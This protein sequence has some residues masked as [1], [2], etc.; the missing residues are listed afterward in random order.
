M[1][2][3]YTKISCT[4]TYKQWK[5]YQKWGK[6]AIYNII[7]TWNTFECILWKEYKIFTLKKKHKRL[8]REVKENLKAKKYTVSLDC[9]NSI[10]LTCHFS[11]DIYKFKAFGIKTPGSYFFGRNWQANSKIDMELQTTKTNL[12]KMR[13]D[14]IDSET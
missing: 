11:P 14:I 5:K 13:N 9:K 3:Q 2:E 7:N 10:L 1:Q 6:K 12:R 8:L 4:S